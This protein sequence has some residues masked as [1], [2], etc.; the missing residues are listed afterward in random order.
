MGDHA[1]VGEG[2]TAVV[3][4]AR[5]VVARE[6]VEGVGHA[7]VEAAPLAAAAVGGLLLVV[8]MEAA[9]RFPQPV[10][11]ALAGDRVELAPQMH[12]AVI[13]VAPHPHAPP[14]P[15]PP[16]F[17]R[18]AV[19]LVVSGPAAGLAGELLGPHRLRLGQQLLIGLDISSAG[20]LHRIGEPLGVRL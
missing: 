6:V 9:G 8:V 7:L 20:L 13:I 5:G 16:V 17:G 3:S 2:L 19:G 4:G 12:H 10:G 14:G 11:D 15:Q 18:S 1:D